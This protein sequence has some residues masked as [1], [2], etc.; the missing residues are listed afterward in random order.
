MQFSSAPIGSYTLTEEGIDFLER[1]RQG[2]YNPKY[3]PNDKLNIEAM[4]PCAFARSVKMMRFINE[5]YDGD[6]E[7][8][9][10][11]GQKSSRKNS[12]FISANRIAIRLNAIKALGV[13]M[14]SLE[15]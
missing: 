9:Y 4:L 10:L 8:Y 3:D 1:V 7:K 5:V 6:K 15:D 14:A 11:A 2:G 13:Y 12:R